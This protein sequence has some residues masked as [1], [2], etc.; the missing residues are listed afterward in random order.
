MYKKHKIER[1]IFHSVSSLLELL[2]HLKVLCLFL[3]INVN[4]IVFH[5]F[6]KLMLFAQEYTTNFALHFQFIVHIAMTIFEVGCTSDMRKTFFTPILLFCG[7]VPWRSKSWS[8]CGTWV[9]LFYFESTL[10]LFK[11]CQSN[12]CVPLVMLWLNEGSQCFPQLVSE[13]KVRF[14]NFVVLQNRFPIPT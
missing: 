7:Q 4:V 3:V 11:D 9:G 2:Q 12:I 14:E 6:G 1:T 5:F 10:H 13:L 8:C